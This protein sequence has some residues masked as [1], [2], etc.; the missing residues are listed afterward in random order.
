MLAA[1][2]IWYAV[3]LKPKAVSI[4]SLLTTRPNLRAMCKEFT[5]FVAAYGFRC[6]QLVGKLL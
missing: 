1:H 2:P 6:V 5:Q 4:T 3:T